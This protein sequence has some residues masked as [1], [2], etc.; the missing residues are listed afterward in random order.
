[1]STD[2]SADEIDPWLDAIDVEADARD[3]THFRRIRAMRK[4]AEA[5]QDELRAAVKAARA[6]GDSW[7]MIGL[8]L[9]INRKSAHQ[10]FGEPPHN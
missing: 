5:A 9:G 4:A 3:T 10:L 6:A 8:A 7:T 2:P 1:L